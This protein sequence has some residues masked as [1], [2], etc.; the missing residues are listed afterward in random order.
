[1]KIALGW[2]VVSILALLL[3]AS[4]QR[5]EVGR[6][7]T[8]GSREAGQP[9]TSAQT[10][11]SMPDFRLLALGD[12]YTIGQ[13]VEASARWP[14]QLSERRNGEGMAMSSP[15]IIA[16]TGWTTRQL[17]EALDVQKP[18]GPYDIVTLFIGVNNQFQGRELQEYREEIAT[19]IDRAIALTGG[20]P[21]RVMVL[22]I[23]D[24]SH[25]PFARDQNRVQISR[26]I[27]LFN[28]ANR[29]ETERAAVTYV[30]ITPV[31]REASTDHDLVAG[32]GLHPSE[33]MYSRWV[34]VILPE[35]R[36]ML[37]SPRR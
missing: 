20:E 13:G 25:T 22:S 17:L 11:S 7:P 10:P 9:A 2:I 5:K 12:S 16:R 28:S 4:C 26:E 31:S 23:P 1:M 29:E 32:D 27:D 15:E 8:P 14:S 6:T 33:K 36:A 35:A 19:L 21:S 30:D 18:S 37:R 3:S 34:D 24:W